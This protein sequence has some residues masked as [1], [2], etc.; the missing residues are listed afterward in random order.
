MRKLEHGGLVRFRELRPTS[1]E[2]VLSAA[3]RAM[4]QRQ[5]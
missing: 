4:F 5:R 2:V 1:W 3:G